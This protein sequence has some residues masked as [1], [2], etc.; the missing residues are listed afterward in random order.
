MQVLLMRI[1]QL[2]SLWIVTFFASCPLPTAK[3]ISL[4]AQVSQRIER[5]LFPC[6]NQLDYSWHIPWV[7]RLNVLVFHKIHFISQ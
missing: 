3:S 6:K 7:R 4:R 2:V 5:K 1:I